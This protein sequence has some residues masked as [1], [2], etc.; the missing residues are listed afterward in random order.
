MSRGADVLIVGGGVIGCALARE[1]ARRGVSV[2][3]LERGEIGGEAS[4]AAA[5]LLSPQAE[6]DAPGPLFAA[7]IASRDLYGAWIRALEEESGLAAGY[8]QTGVLR[9]A[10]SETEDLRLRETLAW[11]R[12]AGLPVETREPMLLAAEVGAELSALVRRALFF[13]REAIVHCRRLMAALARSLEVRG[14]DVRT[15]TPV[16]AFRFERGACL[17]V[18]TDSGLVEAAAV[19]DAAGAWAGFDER[20]GFP[21]VRPVR[22]QIVLLRGESPIAT[23]VQSEEI[24]LVPTPDGSVIAGAT[25]EETGFRSEVTAEGVEG[26]IAAARRLCPGLAGARF[27]AA[28]AG[29]RPRSPDGLPILGESG[30]RRLHLATGHF[31]S[32][33]LLA[34]W[35]AGLLADQLTGEGSEAL[36][37]FSITRFPGSVTE[38][39]RER[40]RRHPTARIQDIG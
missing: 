38:K 35:T 29:L 33:I 30:L 16:R 19:V 28:W 27:E 13:P 40:S 36:R 22:G 15:R 26:L 8:R 1:L 20:P 34:P 21:P 9:C 24:Y 5:G 10:L 14:V 3:L 12:H 37:E 18:E 6:A 4:G 32:G 17:G 7:G 11:Q 2:T 25:V 39:P 23:V 31:R